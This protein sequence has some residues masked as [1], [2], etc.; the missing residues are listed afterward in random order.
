MVKNYRQIRGE[1]PLKKVR[2]RV[3]RLERTF[4]YTLAVIATDINAYKTKEPAV[5]TYALG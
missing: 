2:V 3:R 4:K 5:K 1:S